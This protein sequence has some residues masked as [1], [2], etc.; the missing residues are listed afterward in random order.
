MNASPAVRVAVGIHSPFYTP[1]FVAT[2]LSSF[3]REDLEVTICVP[4]LAAETSTWLVDGRVDFV[5]GGPMRSFVA[6]EQGAPQVLVSIAEINSRDGFF[7]LSREAV[8]GF[9]WAD[10]VGK[11]LIL[12]DEAPTPWLCL[13][14]V[15]RKHGLDPGRVRVR[16]GLPASA[17]AAAFCAGKADFLQTGQ[18]MTEEL[19][20]T[21]RAYLA[22]EMAPAVGHIPYSAL[23]VADETRRQRPEL[24]HRVV[25]ALARAQ[26]WVADH[27]EDDIARL[28]APDFPQLPF[29]RLT[30][31]VARYT[32]LRIWPS[33]PPLSRDAFDRLGQILVAGGLIRRA[34]P[35]EALVDNTFAD[36]AA[37]SLKS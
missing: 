36:A 32:R 13:Q 16:R 1:F 23:L 26:R 35:Y 12:F 29:T 33:A 8:S 21:G 25:R 5:V 27:G 34:A 28:I 9:D 20:E 18:P 2:R 11:S 4:A 15:L 22:A 6:A 24:C 7:L 30:A 3:T 31:I 19:L 37:R 17:A 10:L 14:A